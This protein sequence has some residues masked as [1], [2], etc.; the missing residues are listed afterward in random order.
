MLGEAE[1]GVAEARIGPELVVDDDHADRLLAG[2]Q[3]HEQTCR[4]SKEARRLLVD[5]RI[6]EHRVDPLAPP[7]LEHPPRL[8]IAGEAG[9]NRRLGNVAR[10]GL[11]PKCIRLR[12]HDYDQP[13][14]DQLPQTLRDEVKQLR[15]IEL[16]HERVP[17]LIER[18]KLARPRR[19]RLVQA[20]V[21]DGDRR[22]RGEQGDEL[23]ILHAE[24]VAALLLGQ[25]E[26]PVGDAAQ[27]D[28]HAEEAVHRG[29]VRREAH[30]TRVLL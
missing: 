30:R 29:V 12:Q 3:R 16:A 20:R 6:F 22:L 17:D 15:Q 25:I 14:V 18:L 13:R 4:R 26:V 21:L 19:R 1:I 27:E 7:A 10:R 24:R 28:R 2:K 8:R 11:D 9:S 23:F 5:L